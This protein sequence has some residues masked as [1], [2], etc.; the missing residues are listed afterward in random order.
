[1]DDQALPEPQGRG[2]ACMGITGG[3]KETQTSTPNRHQTPPLLE[4][5]AR[6]MV[7]KDHQVQVIPVH[8]PRQRPPSPMPQTSIRTK[9][10][11]STPS[12]S[13]KCI[14]PPH[15]IPYQ[16]CKVSHL[17]P[18]ML[19]L[20]P[21]EQCVARMM[22]TLPRTLPRTI[23]M[24]NNNQRSQILLYMINNTILSRIRCPAALDINDLSQLVRQRIRQTPNT[25]LPTTSQSSGTTQHTSFST[26]ITRSNSSLRRKFLLNRVQAGRHCSSLIATAVSQRPL[27]LRPTTNNDLPHLVQQANCAK[28]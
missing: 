8:P 14:Y 20:D 21:L 12:I 28:H 24:L 17:H 7:T 26:V 1:M 19:D 18:E 16:M 5:T 13:T 23:Y 6:V 22:A 10:T 3:V 11:R 25:T 2:L 4:Y 15:P 9:E 27:R